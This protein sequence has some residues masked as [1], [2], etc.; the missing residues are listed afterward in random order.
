MSD[1]A[2]IIPKFGGAGVAVAG[3]EFKD[4]AVLIVGLM[5]GFIAGGLF[6][7]GLKGFVG[8]P[9]ACYFLN[10]MYLDWKADAAPGQLRA[11][12]YRRG[13]LG[14]S[15]AFPCANVIYVGDD[16]ALHPGPRAV[17][18]DAHAITHAEEI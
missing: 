15:R 16:T 3:V 18:T 4:L 6:G 12:L 2:I 17:A 14:Y 9:V 1:K 13:I 11:T 7:L 5:A 10:V 8:I